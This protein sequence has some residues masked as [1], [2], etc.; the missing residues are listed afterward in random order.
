MNSCKGS[1][2]GECCRKSQPLPG[3]EKKHCCLSGHLN[4]AVFVPWQRLLCFGGQVQALLRDR[5]D[6]NGRSKPGDVPL[7]LE[8]SSAGAVEVDGFLGS[9]EGMEK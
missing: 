5:A 7:L 2:V 6:P 4:A 1:G 9:F 8:A 3:D